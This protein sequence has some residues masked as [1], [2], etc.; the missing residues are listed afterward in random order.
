MI[1][2]KSYA[3]W[4]KTEGPKQVEG[5]KQRVLKEQLNLERETL[6]QAAHRMPYPQNRWI[7][8]LI[9]YNKMQKYIGTY[10]QKMIDAQ[11]NFGKV[12]SRFNIAQAVTGRYSSSSFNLQ[13]IPSNKVVRRSFTSRDPHKGETK[14]LIAD[15]SS[16][17]VRVLAELSGDERLL[18][19]AI[20]GDVHSRS[21][22]QIFNIPFDY[23]LEVI[24]SDPDDQRYSSVRPAFKDMRRRA[25]AFTFQLL[26]GAGAAALAVVLR[27]TDEEAYR[28]IEAWA[29]IYPKAYHYRQLMFE[30]M[31]HTGFLPVID[32]RTIF[33]FKADRTMPV[34]ANYPVQGAAA[35]LMYRAVYHV[36]KMLYDSMIRARLAASVHDELLIYANV[37]CAE[38]AAKILVDG[39]V[40]AWLDIFPNTD[41][42]NLVGKNN[43][44]VI[45]WHWGMKE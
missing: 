11:I 22:A 30:Q 39:M 45:G 44:A 37:K 24:N 25:K 12:Q 27:C 38:Q 19:D 23:F 17:E 1:D 32:G 34:A 41:T 14:L 35:S 43:K 28:A 8:A 18:Y 2:E 21:A 15:Y 33:V 16:I 20:Y 42:G 36:H 5:K 13:N 9:I 31:M 40:Q 3:L 7:A 29:T 6:V 10:G 26:Y 4:P